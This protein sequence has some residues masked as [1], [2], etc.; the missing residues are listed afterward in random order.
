MNTENE[1]NEL[2]AIMKAKRLAYMKCQRKLTEDILEVLASDFGVIPPYVDRMTST[3][4]IK[5]GTSPY[6]KQVADQ[7]ATKFP[8]VKV[9]QAG[10]P[11]VASGRKPWCLKV[12]FSKVSK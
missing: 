10:M 3:Y 7:I 4:R 8:E 12:P 6:A 11:Y 9:V 5:I 2:K 1:L